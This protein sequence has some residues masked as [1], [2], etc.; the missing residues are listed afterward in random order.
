M[1]LVLT[2][3]LCLTQFAAAQMGARPAAARPAATS[4]D[5]RVKRVLDELGYRYEVNSSNDFKLTQPTGDGDRTQIVY[6]NSN[7]ETYGSLEIR[8][9]LAPAFLSDGPLSGAVA[10]RL[11]RENNDA[12]LGA[13][14]IVPINSGANAGKYL[15][16]FCVQLAA[17]S[18]AETLR[19]GIKSA[20]VLA[21]KLEK[22]LTGK[23]D[24]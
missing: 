24:Y 14:R 1:M 10:N 6:V 22:E 11:L 16:L 15:A 7:T 23:D 12:K 4:G 8:E 3:L 18:D 5:A 9:V 13:W 20:L 2:A 17:D 21:D 19:L